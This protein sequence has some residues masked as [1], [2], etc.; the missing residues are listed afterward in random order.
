MKQVKTWSGRLSLL[1]ML[2][3]MSG[4]FG[5]ENLT[6]LDPKGPQAQWIF[7]NM[8]LS[9]YIMAFVTLVVF[10]IFFYILAKFRRKE[11][12]DE[13]PK[14]VHGSTVLEITWTVI[15]ILLLL[16]LFVPTIMG[17]FE[18]AESQAPEDVEDAVYIDVTGHQ[19][20]W[21]FDY[22]EGF[23]AGQEVYIPTGERV[24]FTLNAQD[25]IHS[26]WVP[27]L[28]GKI[29]TVPGIENTLW[30]EATEPGTYMGKCAELC[31]PSHA[32]MDFK[33]IA[34]EREDYDQW[35][36]DM[37]AKAD[38][39][40][41]EDS[42]VQQGYEVFQESCISCHAV[43]GAGSASGPTLT[44]F[45]DRKT[46]AGYLENTDEQ[47]EAWIRN[48]DEFKQDNNMIP[49]PE[50]DLSADEMDA[51]IAYLRSLD[52]REEDDPE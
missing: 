7:N 42:S 50:E 47:L 28:G 40:Q 45:A 44:N 24:Y 4:C 3:L 32:L 22:E 38:V 34:L 16:V 6:A 15:P 11:G 43:G 35:V 33:L 26:F 12:D 49:F 18:F 10:A 31:G 9:L 37:V 5:N 20:W 39:E 1:V 30:L 46:I 36:E 21:Q 48:P 14:Q 51:L 8:V 41:P 52:V 17:T 23:T 25:V 29:D 2:L 19:Y 13:Y 27:A